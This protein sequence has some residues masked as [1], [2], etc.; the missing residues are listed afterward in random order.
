MQCSTP[1]CSGC[2]QSPSA[3]G[4]GSLLEKISDHLL[5]T[6]SVVWLC[7]RRNGTICAHPV[8]TTGVCCWLNLG[9]EASLGL[10]QAQTRH[11][12]S[13]RGLPSDSDIYIYIQIDF[14]EWLSCACC[15]VP[16]WLQWLHSLHLYFITCD[17]E[18]LVWAHRIL[19]QP[20]FLCSLLCWLQ[21][22]RNG[23]SQ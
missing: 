13:G 15:M 19:N 17:C 7:H 21:K 8:C 5:C 22:N 18:V 12:C 4:L 2:L 6:P 10:T 3:C 9:H 14:E 20:K 16:S 1:S 11:V 23:D